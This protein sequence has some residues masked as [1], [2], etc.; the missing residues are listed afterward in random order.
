MMDGIP[1][2]AILQV[3]FCVGFGTMAA[4]LVQA[5]QVYFYQRRALRMLR[6][7]EGPRPE[8]ILGNSR[9]KQKYNN[10]ITSMYLKYVQQ[11]TS[12]DKHCFQLQAPLFFHGLFGTG[13]EVV[14]ANEAMVKHV[15]SDKFDVYT[16]SSA[17]GRLPESLMKWLGLGIFTIDHGPRACIPRDGGKLW[18]AQ[19]R[20]ALS[21]FSKRLFKDYYERVF[22]GN[23]KRVIEKLNLAAEARTPVDLQAAFF[24]YTM[25]SFGEIAFGKKVG[26]IDGNDAGFGVAFDTAHKLTLKY[27]FGN[28]NAL[29]FRELFPSFLGDR[30]QAFIDARSPEMQ[31]LN[32]QT[33]ILDKYIDAII[34]ERRSPEYKEAHEGKDEK[35]QS[36]DLLKLFMEAT[37]D[38]GKA[39]HSQEQLRDMMLSFVIAGRDT[40]ATTLTW[41]FY[42]LSK[43]ENISVL[44]AVFDEVDAILDGSAPTYDSLPGMPYL[45]GAVYEALRLHPPVPNIYLS[46]KADDTLPDGTT[47]PAGTRVA[48]SVYAM[49]RDPARYAEPVSKVDPTRWIPFQQP[50]PW[51]FPVFKAGRRICIGRDMAVFE[52]SVAAVMLLQRFEPVL[53]GHPQNYQYAQK[54]TMTT[55]DISADREQ[56]MVL[57]KPRKTNGTA[58]M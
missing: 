18:S 13:N 11:Y 17:T 3:V 40:T 25:D 57:L 41:L 35:D 7:Y 50:S 21:I 55:K 1:Y 43:P 9:E 16:K 47:L 44:Y 39:L 53:V 26:A 27:A 14:T 36:H 2:G 58:S 15:M 12:S 5:G 52:I 19:R 10:D 28:M 8:F 20:T 4:V 6:G 56:L 45:R 37:G 30:V 54:L 32:R 24:A 51:E 22:V 29:L 46:A 23:A 33:Q 48:V 34:A 49:G 38:D 31:E 42:E